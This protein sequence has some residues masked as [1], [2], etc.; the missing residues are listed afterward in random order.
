MFLCETK[1]VSQ[2]VLYALARSRSS[3]SIQSPCP[4]E[5]SEA[6]PVLQTPDVKLSPSVARSKHSISKFLLQKL[7]KFNTNAEVSLEIHFLILTSIC[8]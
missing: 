6:W 1:A 5:V 4:P 8:T 2:S 7:W 3:V